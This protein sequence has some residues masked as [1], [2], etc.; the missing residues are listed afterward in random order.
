MSAEN[1]ELVRSIHPGPASDLA[2]LVGDE[3]VSASWQESLEHLFDES[4]QGVMRRADMPPTSHSGLAGLRAAWLE[5]LEHWRSYRDEI[6]DVI[7]RGEHVVVIHRSRGELKSGAAEVT[8]RSAT[9]W[10]VRDGRVAKVE[11]N[12]PYAE[13]MGSDAPAGD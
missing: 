1:V 9:I 11:F 3:Q 2:P 8:R 4:V 7:D 6:E 10:T 12:V 13:V 5:W